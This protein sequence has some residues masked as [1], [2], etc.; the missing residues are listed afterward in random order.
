MACFLPA[1]VPGIG[2]LLSPLPAG[3]ARPG[4]LAFPRT[5][6]RT[7]DD[8]ETILVVDDNRDNV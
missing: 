5:R 1:I 6:G 2:H 3:G 4:S 7:V 8:K